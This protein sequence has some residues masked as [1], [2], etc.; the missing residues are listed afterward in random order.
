[1]ASLLS[2]VHYGTLLSLTDWFLK[3]ISVHKMT[4]SLFHPLRVIGFKEDH[5]IPA[6]KEVHDFLEQVYNTPEEEDCKCCHVKAAWLIKRV[7][8]PLVPA[9]L[10]IPY[11]PKEFPYNEDVDFENII[12]LDELTGDEVVFDKLDKGHNKQG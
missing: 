6:P 5:L 8:R 4:R 3:R 9:E 10:G 1:M 12:I 2:K 7:S 11:V